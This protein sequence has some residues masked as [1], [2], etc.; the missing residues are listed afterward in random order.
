MRKNPATQ[1]SV[2]IKGKEIV[3]LNLLTN[4]EI[5]K[6][7]IKADESKYALSDN[8]RFLAIT[9]DNVIEV[10]TIP[11]GK[12]IHTFEEHGFGIDSLVFLPNSEL[13]LSV[14]N[15]QTAMAWS[16]VTQKRFAKNRSFGFYYSADSTNRSDN[17]KTRR[18]CIGLRTCLFR[19]IHR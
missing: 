13:I 11:D 15:K 16:P 2:N 19:Y 9:S 4:N 5:Y 8:G 18:I 1:F 17:R 10:F 7:K 6:T 3:I 12:K 14:D